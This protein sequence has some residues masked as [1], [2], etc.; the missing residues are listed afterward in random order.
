MGLIVLFGTIHK[1][2][3][4]IFT[5]LSEKKKK[6]F[7]FRKINESQIGPKCAFGSKLKSQFILLFNLFLLL[8]MNHTVLFGTIYGSHYIISI[9]FYLYLQ[10]FQ[11]KIFCFSK[12]SRSQIDHKKMNCV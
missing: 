10:Y 3:C 11:Q 2:H 8:F 12:I 9:N 1:F 4:T 7:S 6:K 5:V